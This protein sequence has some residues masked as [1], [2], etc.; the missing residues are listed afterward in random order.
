VTDVTSP[1]AKK[2][3]AL[4]LAADRGTDD[5]V[6][7]AGG[8]ACK[9]LVPVAGIPMLERV[10]GALEAS[11]SVDKIAVSLR[12]TNLLAE[13]DGLNQA[14]SGGRVTAV[15]AKD[16]PSRSVLHA[17]EQ[18][19]HPYPLLITTADHAL[20]T[21]EM[22]DWFC[23]QSVQSGADV[24]A[25]LTSSRI[26][27]SRYPD[28]VRTY[29]KFRDGKY[30]GSNLFSLLTAEGIKGPEIWRQAEQHR[31]QPWKIARVFGPGL[32][33]S[34]LCRWLTLEDAFA[35]I[36]V[37]VGLKVA[38]ITMPF[39]EAAIDVDNPQDLEMV[40]EILRGFG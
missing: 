36:G 3:T 22:V 19:G 6:A 23:T 24:C 31:K 9:S 10:I 30:S 38:P 25:G 32:L 29:L 12:D 27:L 33:I 4:V 7:R 1:S 21:A 2:F 34:Y 16:S 39:P 8:M 40:E 14:V 28:S 26:I 37:T 18:L 35:R 5:P 13:F 20:L 15:Q 17:A 11:P